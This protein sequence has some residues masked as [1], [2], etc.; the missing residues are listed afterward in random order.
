VLAMTIPLPEVAG[1]KSPWPRELHGRALGRFKEAG[2][3]LPPWLRMPDSARNE[4]V[5]SAITAIAA[6]CEG[7]GNKHCVETCRQQQ[8]D[9]VV[10]RSSLE[11]FRLEVAEADLE[12]QADTM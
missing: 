8:L 11:G 9:Y 5:M 7:S 2:E 4:E 10:R 1:A 6:Q 12:R 3:N